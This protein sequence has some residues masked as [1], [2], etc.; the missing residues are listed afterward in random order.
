MF[1][2]NANSVDPGEMP[3]LVASHL[4]LLCVLM[5]YL[6]EASHKWVKAT[7]TLTYMIFVNLT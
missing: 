5:F 7:G 1:F 6:Q 3:H 2:T 4:S